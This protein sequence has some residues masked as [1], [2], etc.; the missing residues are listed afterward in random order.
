MPKLTLLSLRGNVH[1]T[2]GINWGSN[3][4]NHTRKYDA[5]IP[6]HLKTIR[7]NHPFFLPKTDP[8]PVLKFTWDDGTKM[9]GKF[10]GSAKNYLDGKR[11]P[12]QIS[13]FPHK[14][15]LG[16]YLRD[17]MGIYSS[18]RVTIEDFNA[19]GRSD[20]EITQIGP[21]EYLLNF[22]V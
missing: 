17:R 9:L 19:Y 4:K 12:K 16:K 1:F 18:R 5:Y 14:D 13:S 20:I 3:K 8:N 15:L 11:Y 6:I 2:G 22:S 10:E 21:G 7:A